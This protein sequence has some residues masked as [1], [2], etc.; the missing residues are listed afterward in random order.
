MTTGNNLEIELQNKVLSDH[1][2]KRRGDR[3]NRKFRGKNRNL[4]PKRATMIR[5][6]QLIRRERRN[7]FSKP[8]RGPLL[9][10]FSS[11]SGERTLQHSCLRHLTPPLPSQR[12]GPS[13]LLLKRIPLG[14]F[15]PQEVL[16]S[17]I[18][19]RRHPGTAPK[20]NTNNRAG[21]GAEIE[22]KG[23]KAIK[24]KTVKN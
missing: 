12:G 4:S 15:S 16:P 2:R 18:E 19:K 22:K 21:T 13:L 6:S 3:F 8:K 5:G 17:S 23:G 9:K 14:K 24:R 10:G 7:S 20:S 1:R 11:I